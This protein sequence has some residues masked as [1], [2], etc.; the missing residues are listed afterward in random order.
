MGRNKQKQEQ[1][2]QNKMTQFFLIN[3]HPYNDII[4][5]LYGFLSCHM[6]VA[7]SIFSINSFV[8]VYL[9]TTS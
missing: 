9:V 3:A 6:F 8:I 2:K 5:L 1:Q 4:F 7:S